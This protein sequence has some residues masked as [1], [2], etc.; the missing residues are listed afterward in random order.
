MEKIEKI[1]HCICRRHKT[2]EETGILLASLESGSVPADA[3][4][5]SI[6]IVRRNT[7]M[8]FVDEND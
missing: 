1:F 4:T 8:E 2:S 6:D 5:G 7:L 3:I